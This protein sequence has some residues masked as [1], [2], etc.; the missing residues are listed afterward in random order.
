MSATTV[1]ITTP[2]ELELRYHEFFDQLA[3]LETRV[4]ETLD[5]LIPSQESS[6][7]EPPLQ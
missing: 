4:R 2:D 3:V 7:T 5:K 1:E 6:T